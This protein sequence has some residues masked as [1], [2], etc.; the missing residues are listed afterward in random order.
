MLSMRI[1]NRL[2]EIQ[3]AEGLSDEAFAAKLGYSRVQWN[4][5]KNGKQP[6]SIRFLIAVKR[7]YPGLKKDVDFF[8]LNEFGNEK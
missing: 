5:I 7:C 3:E 2:K 1:V 4:N 8:I 6:L